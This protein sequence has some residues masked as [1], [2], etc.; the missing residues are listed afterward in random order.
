[1]RILV[2]LL[3]LAA[4]AH[5]QHNADAGVATMPTL[6]FGLRLPDDGARECVQQTNYL[7]TGEHGEF[8]WQPQVAYLRYIGRW[9][10]AAVLPFTMVSTSKG[11]LEEPVYG[12]SDPVVNA[13]F[14]PWSG[15]N[16]SFGIHFGVRIP[17]DRADRVFQLQTGGGNGWPMAFQTGLGT[18]NYMGSFHYRYKTWKVALGLLLPRDWNDN[19]YASQNPGDSIMRQTYPT[20]NQLKRAP[21]LMFR[22]EKRFDIGEG[23]NVFVG[24]SALYK[25]KPDEYYDFNLYAL[26][27]EHDNFV[28]V[29]GTDGLAVNT[30]LNAQLNLG[31]GWGLTGQAGLPVVKREVMMDGLGRNFTAALGVQLVR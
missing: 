26:L 3:L 17:S 6:N 29:D 13:A 15:D 11:Y 16:Y 18:W 12:L 28:A 4:T 24:A 8:Y 19:S 27:F 7:S 9:Q 30:H 23:F 2:L 10:V 25:L 21:E 14:C 5:A 22:A 31:K 1:M 20:S